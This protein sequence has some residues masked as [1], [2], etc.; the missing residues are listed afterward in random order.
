MAQRLAALRAHLV[1]PRH[2]YQAG[3][4]LARQVSERHGVTLRYVDIAD[5]DAVVAALNGRCHGAG[6]VI[7]L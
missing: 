2:A 7:A 1:L 5:T 6:W 4:V 3:M